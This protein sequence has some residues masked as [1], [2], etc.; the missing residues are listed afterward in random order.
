MTE[1][2]SDMAVTRSYTTGQLT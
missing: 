2:R 1:V